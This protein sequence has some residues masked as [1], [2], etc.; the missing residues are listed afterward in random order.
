M[1]DG[2]RR[3]RVTGKRKPQLDD[4]R[5]VV[6]GSRS[7]LIVVVAVVYRSERSSDKSSAMVSFSGMAT[8]WRSRDGYS[9]RLAASVS[10]TRSLSLC[11]EEK[12]FDKINK[13]KIKRTVRDEKK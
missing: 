12:S 10:R 13:K 2:R 5:G 7:F 8:V 6:L 11:R 4:H 1:V 9:R 3:A